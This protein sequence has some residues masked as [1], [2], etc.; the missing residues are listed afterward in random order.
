MIAHAL[1]RTGQQIIMSHYQGT[2]SIIRSMGFHYRS[3]KVFRHV[4]QR[5]YGQS[6]PEPG[7]WVS[8]N[9]LRSLEQIY[10]VGHLIVRCSRS[11]TGSEKIR[12]P[13]TSPTH[14]H[15]QG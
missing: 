10:S 13:S 4:V 6:W 3:L 8:S 9:L 2:T 7:Q 12:I 5:M 11:M 1:K 14:P 15:G